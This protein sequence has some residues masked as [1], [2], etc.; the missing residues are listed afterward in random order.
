MDKYQ[1]PVHNRRLLFPLVGFIVT[2][3]LMTVVWLWLKPEVHSDA[4]QIE[5][6]VISTHQV[7]TTYTVTTTASYLQQA[8]N[9]V[10]DLSYDGVQHGTTFM[11]DTIN[12]EHASYI[13]DGAYWQF[14]RN[15][16]YCDYGISQQPIEDGDTFHIIYMLTT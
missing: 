16:Q 10:P 14:L 9:E 11:V 6:V 2:I 5:I 4:K 3:I 12:G 15:Q 8:M 7:E 1:S 13:E